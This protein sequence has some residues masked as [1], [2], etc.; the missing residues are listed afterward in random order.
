MKKR[1][2]YTKDF[3]DEAVMLLRSSNKTITEISGD[4]GIRHDLLSR[5][6]REFDEKNSFPGN[7]NPRDKEIYEYKKK[8]ALLEEERD[9]LKK[10][11]AIFSGTMK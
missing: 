2:K 4:L 1:R 9:I 8:I 5:W 6:N 3:K 10:A 7:G 11:L